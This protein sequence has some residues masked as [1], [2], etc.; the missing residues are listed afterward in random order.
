VSTGKLPGGKD[1]QIGMILRWIYNDK[2]N[3]HI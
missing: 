1:G 3:D 2:Q